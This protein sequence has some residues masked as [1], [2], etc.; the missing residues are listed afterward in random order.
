MQYMLRER[1][2]GKS[3]GR[4]GLVVGVHAV[5]GAA[6][7]ASLNHLQNKND[8][9]PPIDLVYVAPDTPPP[10][11]PPQPIQNVRTQSIQVPTVPTPP[12]PPTTVDQPIKDVIHLTPSVDPTTQRDLTPTLP[13]PV[14]I[15]V[16]TKIAEPASTQL[17]AAC[18][19]A[20]QVQSNIRYPA[21][22]LRDSLE[23]DVIVRFVVPASGEIKNVA[24]VSS[25]NRAFNNVVIQ[26]VQQF[27]CQ[28]QGRDVL[29]EAPFSFR[30]N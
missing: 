22:A 1:S 28:G 16:P 17:G 26:A 18:P 8:V 3:L 27:G 21:Q 23:G 19:N 10:P 20:A 5:I 30:L 12:I 6:V 24:I 4:L 2:M 9:M 29:V 25:A 14:A 13:T 7:I 15:T 11:L